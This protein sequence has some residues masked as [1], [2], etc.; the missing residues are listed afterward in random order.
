MGWGGAGAAGLGVD[1]RVGTGRV[2]GARVDVLVGAGTGVL[3]GSSWIICALSVKVARGRVD[4]TVDV[5]AATP[6]AIRTSEVRHAMSASQMDAAMTKILER[7]FF[8]KG[9]PLRLCRHDS[10]DSAQLETGTFPPARWDR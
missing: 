9:V 5:L 4:V 7:E 3:V 10:N 8:F 6:R 2:V 1:V